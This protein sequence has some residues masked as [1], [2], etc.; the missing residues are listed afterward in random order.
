M[1][2]ELASAFTT[3]YRDMATSIPMGLK[4]APVAGKQSLELLRIHNVCCSTPLWKSTQVWSGP[5]SE[6]LGAAQQAGLLHYKA[7]VVPVAI[8]PR[9]RKASTFLLI[10][11]G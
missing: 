2:W 11:L 4:G 5:A 9:C 10:P 3:A 8:A 6:G 7:E 1:Q